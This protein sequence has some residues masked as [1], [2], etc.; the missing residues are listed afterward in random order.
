VV[1]PVPRLYGEKFVG[2]WGNRRP[3]SQAHLTITCAASIHPDGCV[4]SFRKRLDSCYF[5]LRPTLA[6][7][8][9]GAAGL[10]QTLKHLLTGRLG[11]REALMCTTANSSAVNESVPGSP[12][13]TRDL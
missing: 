12:L 4:S 8:A 2:Q 3:Y 13:E 6:G 10:Q 1:S 11:C 5:H 9:F 7:G